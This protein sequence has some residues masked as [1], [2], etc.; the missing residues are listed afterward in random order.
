MSSDTLRLFY[1]LWPDEATRLALQQW[2]HHVR[3]R[4]VVPANLHLTL[5]FLGG[6]P[7]RLLPVLSEV[8]GLLATPPMSITLDRIGSFRKSGVVWAGGQFPA[9]LTQMQETLVRLLEEREIAFNKG[10]YRPH[11]T[12]ARNASAEPGTVPPAPIAWRADHLALVQSLTRPEGVHYE[13]VASHWLSDTSPS[14]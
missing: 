14:S 3:G 13:I 1:A 11:V 6:Q 9:A 8:M 7:S 10:G 2:Q 4:L 12:L 5:A